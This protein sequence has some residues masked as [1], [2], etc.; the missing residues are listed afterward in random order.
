MHREDTLVIEPSFAAFIDALFLGVCDPL[1]LAFFDE[2]P[3]HL[4]Y[5]TKHRK[6]DVAELP[7]C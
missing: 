4:S 1:A 5:H 7:T 6:H 2:A 3:L